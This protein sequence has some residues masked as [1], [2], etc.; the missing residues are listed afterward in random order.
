MKQQRIGCRYDGWYSATFTLASFQRS[1][2]D[3]KYDDLLSHFYLS[4]SFSGGQPLWLTSQS[5]GFSMDTNRLIFS[6]C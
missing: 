1:I 5:R 2:G 4:Y 3:G 6:K